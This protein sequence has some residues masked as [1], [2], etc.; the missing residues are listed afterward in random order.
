MK[1][2]HVATHRDGAWSATSIF[3][4]VDGAWV[5]VT[6]AAAKAP[7]FTADT[8]PVRNIAT[9]CAVLGNQSL[10]GSGGAAAGTK[11][12]LH[13]NA[14]RLTL[15]YQ[16]RPDPG[17]GA[18]ESTPLRAWWRLPG[19]AWAPVTF[20]GQVE[21]TL[22]GWSDKTQLAPIQ[23]VYSDEIRGQF[24]A[25]DTVEVMT[26]TQAAAGTVG[27]PFT[28]DPTYDIG[29]AK[30]GPESLG[31]ADYPDFSAIERSARP[32]GILASSSQKASWVGIGDSN[33]VNA[34]R[35]YF[36][37]ALRARGQAACIAG[38][39]GESYTWQLNS[40]TFE[41]RLATA[42][43]YADSVYSALGTNDVFNSAN[44]GPAITQLMVDLAIKSGVK[45]WV[46]GTVPPNATTTDG[47]ATTANQTRRNPDKHDYVNAWLRDGAPVKAGK[48]V[49]A[50]SADADARCTVISF[51]GQVKPG[52][53]AHPFG[54]GWVSDT[55]AVLESS[56]GSGLFRTDLPRNFYNPVDPIHYYQDMHNLQASHLERD[57]KL[58]GF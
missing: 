18:A 4:P 13:A 34:I 55:G 29:V 1:L 46:Q 10:P 54:D 44:A 6:G 42:V 12:I 7:A 52:A 15:L 21:V 30:S 20:G 36:Y 40:G 45:G 43:K 32:S 26:W 37:Q 24:Y 27:A 49:P 2:S 57:L 38:R 35:N 58:M 5:Q 23:D 17:F 41:Y 39:H 31:Q 25:G 33:S 19:Q 3:K 9:G 28:T 53:G 47:Y 50:G 14:D 48:A 16:A 8:G 11:H 51:T 56:V 22:N